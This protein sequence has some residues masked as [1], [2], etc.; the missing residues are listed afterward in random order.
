VL[1]AD[2]HSEVRSAAGRLLAP[3]CD[4]LGHAVDAA[5]L[6]EAAVRL[7]PDVVLLDF[8]LPGGRGLDACRH[9]GSIAPAVKIVAFTAHNDAEIRRAA[10]DAGCA[11][12]VWKMKAQDELLR[13]I[14][15]VL[16]ETARPA[17]GPTA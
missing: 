7:Q 3:D 6:F 16:G 12:F 8:S 11:G 17:K 14:H 9:L 10:F 1:I 5:T 13:T 4:V 15:A 2:D